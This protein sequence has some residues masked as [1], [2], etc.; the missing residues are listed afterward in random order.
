MKIT[1]ISF[2]V[3]GLLISLTF[4]LDI[5][6]GFELKTSLKNAVNPFRTMETVEMFVL[7]FF[8]FLFFIDVVLSLINKRK[9]HQ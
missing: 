2:L 8:V 7:F 3:M 4:C 6:A 1:G 9:K 5:I